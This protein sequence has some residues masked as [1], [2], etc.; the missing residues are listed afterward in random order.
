MAFIPISMAVIKQTNKQTNKQNNK[1]CWGCE[2]IGMLV[3]CWQECKIKL[4][5]KIVP[6]KIKIPKL[7]LACD[8]DIPF[9]GIYTKKLKTES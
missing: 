3:Y 9:L 1:Y 8:P 2:Q 7:E 6:Q 4:L 5:W